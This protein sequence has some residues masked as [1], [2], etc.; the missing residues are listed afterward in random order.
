MECSK[1]M[2]AKYF[3]LPIAEAAN[4]LNVSFTSLKRC[5][6]NM[7]FMRW[8][9]RKLNSLDSLIST[10]QVRIQMKLKFYVYSFTNITSN[11]SISIGK[12]NMYRLKTEVQQLMTTQK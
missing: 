4:K 8:P 5:C 10:L 1:E 2:I 7:G 11:T 3:H 9:H 12:M 6:R